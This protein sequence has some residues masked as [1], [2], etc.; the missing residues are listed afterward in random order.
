M[1]T[2]IYLRQSLD[3]TGE[4]L[5]VAR[6]DEDCSALCERKG[7]H[8]VVRYIDNDTSAT[9]GIR[10]QYQ[11]M[12]Q[13]IRD[14]QIDAVVA[15]DLDRLHRQPRELEDFITLADKMSIALATVGGDTDLGTDQGRLVARIK[16]A[17]AR[18]EIERKSV[19]QK[20]A[21][22]QLAQSG[23]GWGP[24]QFGYTGD[25]ND[26][27]LVPEEANLVRAAYREI[28]AG[29][30]LYG[31]AQDWNK[32]GVTTK[33]G[34]KWDTS[35]LGRLIKNP[36][37]A[38][39]RALH[40]EIV[41]TGKWPA[42]VD[43]DTWRS[44]QSI[45]TNPS[46]ATYTGSRAP[47]H[48][49]SVIVRCGKCGGPLT[50]ARDGGFGVYRCKGGAFGC[51]GVQRRQESLDK[52][53]EELVLR[54][55]ENQATWSNDTVSDTAALNEEATALRVR[56]DQLAV[57]Y[58]EGN[59]TAAQVKIATENLEA[60]MSAVEDKLRKALESNVLD[61]LVGSTKIRETWEALPIDRQR[62]V[63]QQVIE[64]IEVNSLGTK[65]KGV[66]KLSPGHN[67]IVHW[68]QAN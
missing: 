6:Q 38:G 12:L 44:V 13:D 57:D 51:S 68:R 33:R 27:Q 62:S 20:R 43:E 40:G 36:R 39:L 7:W 4:G 26:P 29:R 23:K 5:A 19:R 9:K 28:L 17:V 65:G 59:L 31:I 60:K 67:V 15:W 42:I 22:L 49:L 41:G 66:H 45:I 30:S 3:R 52:W 24:P 2:A 18:A 56:M 10:P 14:G 50:A 34:N 64:N 54:H 53:I 21:H 61:G 25:H 32:Q 8:D 16:G 55:L 11:A 47:K 63:I 46:R 48:L 35:N 1:R 37:N 58:A